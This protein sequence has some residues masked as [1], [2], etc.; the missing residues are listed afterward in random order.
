M[1]TVRELFDGEFGHLLK[2]EQEVTSGG[3]PTCKAI[4][5]LYPDF[6]EYVKFLAYFVPEEY[7]TADCM[8]ALI[9]QYESTLARQGAVETSTSVPAIYEGDGLSSSTLPFTGRVIMYVDAALTDATKQHLATF[10]ADRGLRIQIRDRIYSEV[11]TAQERLLGF[12]SHD[13]RDKDDLVR[14]LAT[15]L[16][17]ARCPVWY[18]EFSIQPGASLVASIDAGLRDS[19]RC[20]VVLSPYYFENTTWARGEFDAVVTR[21]MNSGGDILIPIW[22]NVT[23]DQVAEFSPLV[24]AINAIDTKLGEDAVFDWVRRKLLAE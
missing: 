18:D 11:I 7:A 22:H 10:G 20:V 8:N 17:S 13:S 6:A 1:A 15:R 23:R 3:P 4:E 14:D 5:R 19:K 21:H 9:A 12:I 24:A 2:V 16:R